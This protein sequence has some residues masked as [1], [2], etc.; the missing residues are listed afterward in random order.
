MFF[1]FFSRK[2]NQPLLT[3]KSLEGCRL[4]FEGSN[5]VHASIYQ[6]TGSS[7]YQSINPALLTQKSFEGCRLRVEGLNQVFAQSAFRFPF[8]LSVF[9]RNL[10][11]VAGAKS[12]WT[13][14]E[15][16]LNIRTIN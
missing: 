6:S 14:Y 5:Q 15:G 8:L 2:I 10:E 12:V 4:R 9:H 13:I 16:K 11:N 7:I 3:Q 1:H